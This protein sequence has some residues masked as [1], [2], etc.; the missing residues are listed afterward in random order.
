MNIK[1]TGFALLI[2]AF[3]TAHARAEDPKN[4]IFFGNSFTQSGGGV[5]L[6]VKNIAVAAGHP[7]PYVISTAVG[8]TNLDYHNS[9]STSS[10]TSAIPPGWQ[11]DAA[12]IQEY[13]TRPTTVAAVGGNVPAFL[14]ATNTLYQSVKN[15]SPNAKAV[16]FETWARGPTHSYYPTHFPGPAD[17]Q[18]QLRT[19]YQTAVSNLNATHGPGTARFAPV[20]DAFE[21]AN[22]D[23]GLYSGDIYHASNKGA[24]LISLVIYGTVYQ[25]QTTSDINLNAIGAGLGLSAHDVAYVSAL[26]DGALVPAPSSLAALALGG[27]LAGQ[28]RRR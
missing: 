2:A 20:G 18:A 7:S 28:R 12:V 15:H 10:I 24:L 23:L 17:M 27:L 21:D 14:A 13:S 22:F 16:M 8:G 19:S 11:W 3:L 6:I 25:D 26:A 1:T 9:F 4:I 5:Q